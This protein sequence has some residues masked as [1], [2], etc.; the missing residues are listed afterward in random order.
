MCVC[1]DIIREFKIL[2]KIFAIFFSCRKSVPANV[3]NQIISRYWEI[4][5][6][7]RIK[8]NSF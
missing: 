8:G 6:D 1:T 2:F 7:T 5:N 3:Q 4:S